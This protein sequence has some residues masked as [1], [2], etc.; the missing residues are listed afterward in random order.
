VGTVAAGGAVAK[1]EATA[2]GVK[3]PVKRGAADPIGDPFP[4]D[5]AV[6]VGGV[7]PENIPTAANPIT[8]RTR[9]TSAPSSAY[10]NGGAK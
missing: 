9:A 4:T 7:L 10:P 1:G 6:D 5:G 3:V 2:T 8:T